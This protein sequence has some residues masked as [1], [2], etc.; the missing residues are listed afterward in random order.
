MM[1]GFGSDTYFVDN[2]LDVVIEEGDDIYDAWDEIFVEFTYSLV[3]LDKVE[4]LNLSHAGTANIDATG[5]DL[6]NALYGS[7]GNNVLDGRGGADFMLGGEGNDTIY[8]GAGDD[9]LDGGAGSDVLVGGDGA[10]ALSGGD[11]ADY[12]LIDGADTAI[13]GGAGFDS[14][15]VQTATPV[16]LD[17]GASSIEWVQGNAGNDV[18]DAASQS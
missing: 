18:F 17:M 4:R 9:L 1:G 3:G 7:D 14:A 11:S 15:F 6:N 2:L 12:L 8:G 5:N 10:D 16:T 13:D